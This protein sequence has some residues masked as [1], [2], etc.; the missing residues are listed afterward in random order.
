[1]KYTTTNIM[2]IRE[3]KAKLSKYPDDYDVVIDV[4]RDY[5]EYSEVE[6]ITPCNFGFGICGASAD[7][8]KNA[9]DA[10]AVLL[11]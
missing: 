6:R 8:V 10:N 1:M 4:S 9:D 3:L 11:T 5:E 2:T 7:K